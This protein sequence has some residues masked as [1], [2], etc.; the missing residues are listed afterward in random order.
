[1]VS[2]G[3]SITRKMN[4]DNKVALLGMKQESSKETIA[5]TQ[6]NCSINEIAHSMMELSFRRQ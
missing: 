1:M 4:T 3:Y 2:L 6:I 5:S